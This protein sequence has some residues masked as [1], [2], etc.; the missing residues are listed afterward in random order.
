MSPTSYTGARS[1]ENTRNL[2]ALVLF[3]VCIWLIA[4]ITKDLVRGPV[5]LTTEHP[6]EVEA[7]A[8]SV[9]LA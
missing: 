4:S 1:N 8:L 2:A 3:A 9:R 5:T 6:T 7:A